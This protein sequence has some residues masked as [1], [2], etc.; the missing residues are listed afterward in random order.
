MV[1]CRVLLLPQS[2]WILSSKIKKKSANT[3]MIVLI[4]KI[5]L[6]IQEANSSFE[7]QELD[8]NFKL[9]GHKIHAQNPLQSPSKWVESICR[10]IPL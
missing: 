6:H 3:N 5:N 7:M 9:N 8:S 4:L 2:H 1:P 10:S